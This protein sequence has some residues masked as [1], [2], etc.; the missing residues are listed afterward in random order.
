MVPNGNSQKRPVLAGAVPALVLTLAGCA[1]GGDGGGWAPQLQPTRP[2]VAALAAPSPAASERPAPPG[3]A[4]PASAHAKPVTKPLAPA[5]P[6]TVASQPV[7]G[8]R[9]GNSARGIYKIG[10]PYQIAGQWYVP[11]ED[12]T[13]DRTGVA[14]WYGADFHGKPTANGETF[15]M[16]S[17]SAAHP[18]LP[19]P[20][21]VEVTNLANGKTVIVR[22]NN[23][24]P[25]TRG[26]LIDVSKAA[27][28]ALGFDHLGTAQVRVRY[29]GRARLAGDSLQPSAQRQAANHH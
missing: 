8:P 17:L 27:A 14:S 29:V 9:P 5:I 18:T 12:P 15:D 21:L 3:P 11:R 16:A 25:Y 10:K 24:G 6:V 20:S 26:R 22:V 23:R 19:M 28:V 4:H 2:P 7:A 1:G 13:Y